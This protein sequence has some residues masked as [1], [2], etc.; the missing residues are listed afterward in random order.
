MIRPA[1]CSSRLREA[2]RLRSSCKRS[3][4]RAAG[5][6][7]GSV[8]SGRR[9]LYA[10]TD[11]CVHAKPRAPLCGMLLWG[12]PL[13]SAGEFQNAIVGPA[14]M[15]GL[16]NFKMLW[17]ASVGPT[18][19]VGLANF[20][21]YT[22]ASIAFPFVMGISEHTIRVLQRGLFG[23]SP[24]KIVRSNSQIVAF[25]APKRGNI[26]AVHHAVWLGGIYEYELMLR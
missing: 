2:M 6:R 20:K 17:S 25:A 21:M 15:A 16:A 4:K 11:C 5:S 8:V 22:R 1:M 9:G 18:F 23:N 7:G 10:D 3:S 14:F 19:M 12:R 13:W 26:F 24:R